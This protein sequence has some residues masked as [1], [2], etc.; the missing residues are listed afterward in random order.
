MQGERDG[1][2]SP[3]D[4]AKVR[5]RGGKLESAFRKPHWTGN[6]W[7]KRALQASHGENNRNATRFSRPGDREEMELVT[8]K[9]D[10][11][12]SFPSLSVPSAA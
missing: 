1:A 6:V 4:R 9:G 5:G 12:P 3:E 10:T 2:L 11:F 8:S 7:S